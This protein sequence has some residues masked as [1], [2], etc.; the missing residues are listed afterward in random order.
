MTSPKAPVPDGPYPSVRGAL[1]LTLMALIAAG[2]TSIA[3]IDFGLLAAVGIGQAIGVGAVATLGAQ[4]V[5]EPQ[6]TRLGLRALDLDSIP[7]ILCLV[8]AILLASELDNIAVDW[9]AGSSP[10]AVESF[11]EDGQE[12][13]RDTV[14]D[15]EANDG[16]YDGRKDGSDAEA[17]APDALLGNTSSQGIEGGLRN[18]FD[19]PGLDAEGNPPILF[20]DPDDPASVLQ[21]FVVLVG[22][23]PIVEEF[24]FRGVIQQGLLQRL[25]LLRGLSMVALLWTLLRPAPMGGVARFLAAGLASFALGWAL[26]LVRI[27]TGSILGPI[28]LAS[29]WAAVGLSATILEGKFAMPGLNV[30]GTHLP[31]LVLLASLAVVVWSGWSMYQ[32]AEEKF[33]RDSEG[34][35]KPPTQ[36]TNVTDI[37]GKP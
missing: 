31:A 29:S 26:G 7:L 22:I 21:A 6:A 20:I 8:P 25:G 34:G 27:A 28:L 33:S 18:P 3:F 12:F 24:L 37:S 9:A 23:S 32:T 19:A 15:A 1:M 17:V 36:P 35:P 14:A 5:S 13:W 30:E 2:F 16:G 4:R 11:N 10:V